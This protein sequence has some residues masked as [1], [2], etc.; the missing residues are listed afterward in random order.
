MF[1]KSIVLIS[2]KCIGCL[3]NSVYQDLVH[4][5]KYALCQCYVL[6]LIES[7]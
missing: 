3:R 1:L 2:I 4:L 5:N 7:C 6:S